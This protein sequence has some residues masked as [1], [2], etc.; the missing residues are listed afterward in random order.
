[1]RSMVTKRRTR[2]PCAVKVRLGQ[3]R[4]EYRRRSA[5]W[6]TA[7]PDP[8]SGEGV[9]R[10]RDLG[11]C[12]DRAQAVIS[13][14]PDAICC[15]SLGS[16]TSTAFRCSRGAKRIEYVASFPRTLREALEISI[17][18]ARPD[19]TPPRCPLSAGARPGSLRRKHRSIRP[20]ARSD[21]HNAATSGG[22]GECAVPLHRWAF[23]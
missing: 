11:V 13:P 6:A 12:H 15:R 14:R 3:V 19:R 8:L 1:M 20:A 16:L 18:P 4:T 21:K 5:L 2:E 23:S 7:C 17:N 22:A 10:T 9:T